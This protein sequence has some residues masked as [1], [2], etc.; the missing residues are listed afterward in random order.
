MRRPLAM[1][2]LAVALPAGAQT[3]QDVKG[4]DETFRIDVGG[5]IQSFDTT[6]RLGAEDG[7]AGTEVSL[8][9]TLGLDDKQTDLRFDG[10][11]RL[12][13][14][15]RVD[16]AYRGWKREG[17]SVLL[18]EIQFGE[19]V[20]QAGATVDTQ[21]RVQLGELYYSYSVVNSGETEIGMMLGVSAYFNKASVALAASGS[22]GGE[23]TTREEQSFVA[24]IPAVGLH[25]R[26]TLLPGF[27]VN[28]KAKWVRASIS[29][30]SGSLL[31]VTAGMDLFFSKNIGI[32]AAYQYVKVRYE[33]E[34]APAVKLEY[35][36]SGPL[37][38]VSVTF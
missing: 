18:Q 1:I 23:V 36:T 9:E 10:Y 30:K 8:E 27:F 6:V 25:L 19:D 32:G 38:Y 16:F 28:A 7:R 34:D 21:A 11:L 37:A 29:G 14:H 20:Y 17:S 24:P 33:D 13:R 22:G 5:F 2:L 15:A 35:K 31:D 3:Y 4:M 12:G 26:Y